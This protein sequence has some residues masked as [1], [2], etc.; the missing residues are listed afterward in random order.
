MTSA[1]TSVRH[2]SLM[3]ARIRS[4]MAR[5]T[6]PPTTAPKITITMTVMRVLGAIWTRPVTHNM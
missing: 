1:T 2:S 6:K 5:K 4:A 3:N